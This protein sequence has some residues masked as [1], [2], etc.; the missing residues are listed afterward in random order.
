MNSKQSS[1]DAHLDGDAIQSLLDVGEGHGGA[2]GSVRAHL[3]NCAG[4]RARVGAW[5]EVFGEL[6][7]LRRFA[8][9]GRLAERVMSGI[10]LPREA[11]RP[12][13]ARSRLSR[14]LARPVAIAHL[15]GR[16]LQD[17]ADGTLSWQR[18]ARARAH[19]VA[20]AQCE[21]RLAGW[22]RLMV[23]LE[24]LPSLAPTAGFAERAMARWR[25]MAEESAGRSQTRRARWSWPRSPRGWAWAGALISVPTAAFVTVAVFVSSFPQ[26]TASG[27]TTYLWW[28]ARDALSAFGSSVLGALMQSGAA[29]RAYTLADY[30]LASP[31]TAAAGAAAFTTL[32]LASVWVL[33][34][35]L[36]LARIAHRHVH[37]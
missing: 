19:L 1:Y 2:S 27:L 28:Q 14:W 21:S 11:A 29:F 4:C 33:N 18:A 22:R 6:G 16:R 23:A 10:E 8:P 32:T 31:G 15:S 35:N 37:I 3:A 9:P 7:R 12:D 17:L 36:G 5:R 20:C 25:R 24:G 30:L 13:G 26:L 34:R